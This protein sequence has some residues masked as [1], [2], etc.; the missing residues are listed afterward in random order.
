MPHVTHC[1]RIQ[2]GQRGGQKSRRPSGIQRAQVF[3]LRVETLEIV[4]F[5][6]HQAGV[7]GVT[8][9]IDVLWLQA[10]LAETP[11]RGRGGKFPCGERHRLLAVLAAAEALFLGGGHY[12]SVNDQRSGRIMEYRIDSENSHHRSRV[13]VCEDSSELARNQSTVAASPFV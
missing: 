9:C 1:R 5:A 8:D 2:T 6:L 12:L 7:V 10:G 11:F 13:D 3:P 4:G